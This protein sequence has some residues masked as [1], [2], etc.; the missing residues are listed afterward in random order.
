MDEDTREDHTKAAAEIDAAMRQGTG[1]QPLV[2]ETRVQPADHADLRQEQEEP[3]RVL[4]ES[5]RREHGLADTSL[6]DSRLP[7]T[8]RE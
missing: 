4:H 8:V 3:G 2:H 7:R 1:W 6:L 5:F